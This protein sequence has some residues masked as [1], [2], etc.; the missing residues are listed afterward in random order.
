[1]DFTSILL[2]DYGLWYL[3][4]ICPTLNIMEIENLSLPSQW[5]FACLVITVPACFASVSRQLLG[6]PMSALQ[7]YTSA[8]RLTNEINRSPEYTRHR[9]LFSL[10]V[11]GCTSMLEA[12]LFHELS[13]GDFPVYYMGMA[14]TRGRMDVFRLM[15]KCCASS[16]LE[17]SARLLVHLNREL[18]RI[19]P[20]PSKSETLYHC[21]VQVLESCGPLQ[22]VNDE[23]AI[24]ESLVLIFRQVLLLSS[25]GQTSIVSNSDDGICNK[26]VRLLLEAGLFRDS[27]LPARYWSIHGHLRDNKRRES[28]L[29]LAIYVRNVYAIKLLLESGYNVDEVHHG[30][31]THNC[32]EY[33][34]TPL[35]YAIW[36]GFIEIVTVLLAAGADVTKMGAQG[37]TATEMSKKCLLLPIPRAYK[38]FAEDIDFKDRKDEQCV[39]RLIFNMVCADLEAKHGMQYDQFIDT[40]YRRNPTGSCLRFAGIRV[41]HPDLA[42]Y[43]LMKCR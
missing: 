42:R 30:D 6:F 43:E 14:T 4:S 10:I 26:I 34:G 8:E 12:L 9:F 20:D 15:L 19:L 17:T 41:A 28:P 39:R 11:G 16:S 23:H 18:R 29:T 5:I 40:I 31:D 3:E 22:E 1:M 32:K 7:Y 25:R 27:K 2:T 35:T 36:L 21:L 37:Q 38:D 33:R 24:F 13:M